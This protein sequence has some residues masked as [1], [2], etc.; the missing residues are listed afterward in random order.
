LFH[1]SF[2]SIVLCSCI[3]G[4]GRMRFDC[5]I[6]RLRRWNTRMTSKR[7]WLP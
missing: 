1:S 5:K 6:V 3:H 7:N 4:E 2:S